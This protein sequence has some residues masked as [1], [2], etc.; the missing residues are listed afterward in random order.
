M[1]QPVTV[2]HNPVEKVTVLPQ[3]NGDELHLIEI[4]VNSAGEP[5]QVEGRSRDTA[6]DDMATLLSHQLQV[7]RPIE[8]TRAEVLNQLFKVRHSTCK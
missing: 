7:Q 6:I 2:V 8:E 5:I 3:G 4:G 1:V